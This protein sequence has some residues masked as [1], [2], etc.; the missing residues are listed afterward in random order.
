MTSELLSVKNLNILFQRDGQNTYAVQDLSFDI[1]TGETLAI[2]GE[3]GSGKSVSALACLGLLADSAIV[4]GS[5]RWNSQTQIKG[6]APDLTTIRGS[7]AGIIFQE[8]MTSLNPLHTIEKQIGEAIRLHQ[9]L[10]KARVRN[11]ILEL[12]DRVGIPNAENRLES[13][14]HQLSGGQ[15]QRVM[16]AMA[17]ANHP[18]LLIA[19]EPT[20]ALDVTIEAQIIDLIQD[21]QRETGMA[22][23]FI[24]HDLG[25]V[26]QLADRVI[27][28]KNGK[29]IEQGRKTQIFNKP[30]ADY[31]KSLV[32]ANQT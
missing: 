28:M 32:E 21:I 20:T 23:L 31:T 11:R 12:L 19:D 30:K 7:E 16:I 6:K 4:A 10:D 24:S 1:H 29:V 9:K 2:V 3:S 13:Y 17:L 27:V 14:P 22:M 25:V 8:P 15:R 26:R 18:K 5:I